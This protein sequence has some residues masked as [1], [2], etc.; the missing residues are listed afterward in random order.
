MTRMF[1]LVLVQKG[2]KKKWTVDSGWRNW[3]KAVE[4][5]ERGERF[6]ERWKQTRAYRIRGVIVTL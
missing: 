6:A 4:V 5:K 1:W 3:E 2:K